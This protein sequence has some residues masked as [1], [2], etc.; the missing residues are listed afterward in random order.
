MVGYSL[1]IKEILLISDEKPALN[2]NASS[3]NTLHIELLFLLILPWSGR[4]FIAGANGYPNNE[5]NLSMF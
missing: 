5:Q 2:E 3:G 4:Q 1:Q